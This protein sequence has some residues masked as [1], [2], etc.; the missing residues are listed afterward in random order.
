MRFATIVTA[1]IVAAPNG[2][3]VSF[4]MPVAVSAMSIL[5]KTA[6]HGTCAVRAATVRLG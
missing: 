2:S 6:A 3:T 5:P 4:V 1:A